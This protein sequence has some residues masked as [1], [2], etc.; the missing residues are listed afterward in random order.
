MDA[1]DE[2][3]Y[4]ELLRRGGPTKPLDLAKALGLQTKKDVNPQLYSLEKQ[5][6]A[7]KTQETPP[8]WVAIGG[9]GDA[10]P[11]EAAPAQKPRY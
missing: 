1:L 5:G 2:R 3:A 10:P 6:R 8:L 9:L 4:A 11:S 7:R